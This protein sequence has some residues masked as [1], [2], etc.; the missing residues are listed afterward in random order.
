MTW[1]PSTRAL[2]SG[3]AAPEPCSYRNSYWISSCRYSNFY[4][5]FFSIFEVRAEGALKE[6][7]RIFLA[8]SKLGSKNDV[9]SWG[10]NSGSVTH[11]KGIFCWWIFCLK[12]RN[13]L[14]LKNFSLYRTN[15]L[16]MG[17][18]PLGNCRNGAIILWNLNFFLRTYFYKIIN[19]L[20]KS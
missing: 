20:Y 16:K 9:A 8:P 14:K 11:S 18:H 7:W 2:K 3:N 10:M 13:T 17:S 6:G 4:R 15:S 1:I 19:F 5:L 12:T